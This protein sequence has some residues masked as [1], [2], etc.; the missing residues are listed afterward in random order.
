MEQV[1]QRCC[2]QM[3]FLYTVDW[4]TIACL[5]LIVVFVDRVA[6]SADNVVCRVLLEHAPV[7]Y[8]EIIIRWTQLEVAMATDVGSLCWFGFEILIEFVLSCLLAS[9]FGVQCAVCGWVCSRYVEFCGRAEK[10]TSRYKIVFKNLWKATISF[11]MSVR[12]HGT[13]RLPDGRIFMKFDISV[14]FENLSRGGIQK[15]APLYRHWGSVQVVRSIGVVEVHIH[16]F[17]VS[18]LDVGE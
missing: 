5:R 15:S 14:F 10:H 4:H 7:R 13:S 1:S 12:P 2:L 17:F 6:I 8:P 9:V 11:V 16:S 18:A 3:P